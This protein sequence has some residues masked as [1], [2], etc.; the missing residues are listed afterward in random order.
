MAAVLFAL[1]QSVRVKVG[2]PVMSVAVIVPPHC[3]PFREIR[4]RLGTASY[5]RIRTDNGNS[6]RVPLRDHESY[7]VRG[8]YKGREALFWPKV[9]DLTGVDSAAT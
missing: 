2:G 8:L 5:V 6:D 4:R 7:V 3:N 9:R 1:G